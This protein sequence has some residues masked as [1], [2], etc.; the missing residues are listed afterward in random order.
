[1]ASELISVL[2]AALS[3]VALAL[4]SPY[5]LFQRRR[6]HTRSLSPLDSTS[7]FSLTSRSWSSPNRPKPSP[8]PHAPIDGGALV[9]LN[10]RIGEGTFGPKN[11][12]F[13]P[14][15]APRLLTDRHGLPEVSKVLL[16]GVVNDKAAE[17]FEK[18]VLGGGGV[19]DRL[20]EYHPSRYNRAD[21]Q[22][23]WHACQW[24]AAGQTGEGQRVDRFL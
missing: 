22:A 10:F 7:L 17:S 11:L 15:L 20:L 12:A 18:M 16:T 6:E 13:A 5:L 19:A 2:A 9:V 23:L 21:C 24:W 4:L 3:R 14:A 1:M 8:P